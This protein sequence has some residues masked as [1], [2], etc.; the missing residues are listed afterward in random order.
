[1]VHLIQ[2]EQ[3]MAFPTVER[4]TAYVHYS[5]ER[6]LSYEDSSIGNAFFFRSLCMELNSYKLM[7]KWV[8]KIDYERGE[9]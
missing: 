6:K 4:N 8:S 7:V 5:E 3:S 1:M 2:R 9:V